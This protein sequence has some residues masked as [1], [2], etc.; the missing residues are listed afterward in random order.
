[1]M[2]LF[3]AKT[4]YDYCEK[5]FASFKTRY[6]TERTRPITLFHKLVPQ[7]FQEHAAAPIDYVPLLNSLIRNT[8]QDPEAEGDEEGAGVAK[9]DL[10]MLY[11]WDTEESDYVKA[12]KAILATKKV[13]ALGLVDFP[14]HSLKN[15]YRAGIDVAVLEVNWPLGSLEK[16]EY[17][18]M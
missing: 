14:L 15:M 8:G 13:K 1:M 10:L 3:A 16:K 4:H 18:D 6:Q 12:A 9:L 17:C 11:W 2:K 5:Q 7:I